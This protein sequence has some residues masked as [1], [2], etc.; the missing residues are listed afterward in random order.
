MAVSTETAWKAFALVSQTGSILGRT[1]DQ[2]LR[3][4]FDYDGVS[5]VIRGDREISV[6]DPD[7]T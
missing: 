5:V 1:T 2:S 7:D 4:S 6:T 3:T